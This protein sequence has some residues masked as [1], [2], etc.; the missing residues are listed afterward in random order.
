MKK[1][2]IK[3]KKPLSALVVEGGGMRGVFSAGVLDSFGAGGFDPFDLYVGVSAGAC[4]LASHLAGQYGRNFH[5]YSTYSITPDFISFKKYLRGGHFMDLDWLWESTIRDYRLDLKRI[6]SKLKKEKKEYLVGVTSINTGTPVFLIPDADNLEHL[7]KVSSAIPL[8]YRK[9]LSIG[10]GTALDGGIADP[11]PVLE[12]YRRGARE[13]T[14]IR[15]RSSDYVK[16]KSPMAFFLPVI[17]RK[18]PA[19]AK[20]LVNRADIYMSSVEFMNNPP[21]DLKIMQI[22]PPSNME[23]DRVTKN[24]QIL[25]QTYETGIEYGKMFIKNSG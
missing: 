14:V 9:P 11:I 20:A 25:K 2:S 21:E 3:Q 8:L 12:A 5:I 13:I 22:A 1:Q 17:F 6:F 4:N 7:L 10:N 23:A 18:Y 16:K 15:S 24:L 19:L